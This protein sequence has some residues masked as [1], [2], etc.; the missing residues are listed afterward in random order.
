MDCTISADFGADSSSRFLLQ[1]GLTDTHTATDVT[2]CP[3][4]A[5]AI[6]A[7]VA[8]WVNRSVTSDMQPCCYLVWR[9][10]GPLGLPS[11][12][13]G[14]TVV[15]D[16][17]CMTTSMFIIVPHRALPMLLSLQLLRRQADTGPGRRTH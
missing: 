5:T 14:W 13:A 12:L 16:T 8:A 4:H 10:N 3:T 9:Q 15:V 7:G 1:H 17:P 2:D 11:R 6:A